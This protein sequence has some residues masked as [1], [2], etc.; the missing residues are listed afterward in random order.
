MRHKL[1]HSIL[2][3][4]PPVLCSLSACSLVVDEFHV[5]PDAS[6]GGDGDTD[7]DMDG[8]G[9]VDGDGDSDGDADADDLVQCG[10]QVSPPQGDAIEFCSVAA[11]SFFVGCDESAEACRDDEKPKHKVTLS[12]FHLQKSEVTVD[13]FRNFVIHQPEWAEGGSSASAQCDASYLQSWTGDT[14]P[15]GSLDL[16]VL[17]VCWYAAR[18]FCEWLGGDYRLPTEAEWETAARGGNDGEAGREYWAYPF[19]GIPSCGKANYS[20][21]QSKATAAGSLIGLSFGAFV[22]MGGNAWEWVADWYQ[23]DY[24][25]DPENEDLYLW[26]SCNE[27]FTWS[28]PGGAS[29]GNDKVLRGGSWFHNMDLMRSAKRQYLAPASSSNLAGFRCAGDL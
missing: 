3:F 19:E 21:C 17:G 14:P 10:L 20:G 1:Q 2:I 25:C 23:A 6:V 8:D 11:V 22:D 15:A 4:L 24:Y 12:A 7:G 13:M 9:D 29:S 18:A 28:D 5:S 27:T 26:P 16:P